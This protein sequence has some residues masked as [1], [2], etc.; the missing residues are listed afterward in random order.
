M[1]AWVWHAASV[2]LLAQVNMTVGAVSTVKVFVQDVVNGAQL[3]VYV[4]VTV[5]NPPSAE[6]ATGI[7]G[8]VVNIPLHPPLA[9]VVRS[10]VANEASMAAWVCP[11]GSVLFEA[12]ENKTEGAFETVKDL[13]HLTGSSQSLVTSHVTVC[14]PP[15]AD[16]APALLF[17]STPLQPPVNVAD[18]SQL[19]KAVFTAAWDWQ[20]STVRLVAQFSNTAGAAVTV[21]VFIHE[22]GGSQSLVTVQVTVWDPPQANGVPA[23]LLVS[24]PLH[25]PEN[26]V[27]ASQVS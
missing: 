1:A 5:V 20:G 2:L 24:A 22:T 12:H 13:V 16:G 6:G 3:L 23:L 8:T 21:K 10:H 19:S 25:P 15:H 11:A 18:A 14:V 26:V 9:V 27:D 17:V 4:H 7:V